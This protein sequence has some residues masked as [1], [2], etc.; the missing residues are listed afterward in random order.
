[1]I[2]IDKI[3]LLLLLTGITD[4]DRKQTELTNEITA[5]F[6]NDKCNIYFSIIEAL[7]PDTFNDIIIITLDIN[8]IKKYREVVT[9]IDKF[10]NTFS[11]CLIK[12]NDAINKSNRPIFKGKK[13]KGII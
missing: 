11:D 5:Y 1:M 13:E 9:T 12:I 4:I 7:T 10:I 6:K 8:T 3:R 2:D